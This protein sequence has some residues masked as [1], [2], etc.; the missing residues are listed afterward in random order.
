MHV[1]KLINKNAFQWDAYRPLQWPSL[2]ARGRG[3]SA[4][5][6][7]SPLDRKQK[8]SWPRTFCFQYYIA[9][10]VILAFEA[11]I[12]AHQAQ[13]YAPESRTKPKTGIIFREIRRPDADIGLVECAKFFANYC[14]YKFG[15]EVSY[16]YYLCVSIFS[17]KQKGI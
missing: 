12:Y 3:V 6:A 15:L 17:D 10:V 4:R 9:I 11:I 7:P 8:E 13:Y 2:S 5:Q 16:L 14:F 1:K